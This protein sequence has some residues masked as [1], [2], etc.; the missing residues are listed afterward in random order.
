MIFSTYINTL[1]M[2]NEKINLIE[3]NISNANSN[4]GYKKEKLEFNDV[5]P[6]N[7]DS[8]KLNIGSGIL[9]KKNNKT[10]FSIGKKKE[11]GKSLDFFINNKN[12]FFKIQDSSNS[13]FYTKNGHFFLDENKNIVN[14]NGMH[15]IGYIENNKNNNQ[16]LKMCPISLKKINKTMEAKKTNKL[17]LTTTLIDSEKKIKNDFF[18]NKIETY[19]FKKTELVFDKRGK[20]HH[21][22]LYFKKIS[23]HIWLLYPIDETE[24]KNVKSKK[25]LLEFD[26]N[27][28]MIE[29]DPEDVK[30]ASLDNQQNEEFFKIYKNNISL[31]NL[32]KRDDFSFSTQDGYPAGKLY[33][34][35]IENNGNIIASYDNNQKRTIGKI[36]IINFYNLNVLEK[37]GNDFWSIKKNWD[38]KKVYTSIDNSNNSFDIGSLESSNVDIKNELSNMIEAQK[39]YRSVVKS[40]QIQDKMI[41][42]LLNDIK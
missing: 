4:N 42:T 1:K 22:G 27:R 2:F 14:D 25:I 10:D 11:T 5:F 31:K 36:P 21:I 12:G 16:N 17:K 41:E 15:L 9:L 13:I 32:D 24:G 29:P 26:M 7:T 18:P 37:S 19:N 20:I 3:K 23:Q 30:L 33:K 6:K 40:M 8:N 38:K 34:F 35:N 39:N 28:E